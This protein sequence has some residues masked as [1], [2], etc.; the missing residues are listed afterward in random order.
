M[1]DELIKLDDSIEQHSVV[2][3]DRGVWEDEIIN[4]FSRCIDQLLPP[5][6]LMQHFQLD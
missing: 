1:I 6:K 3:Y 5:R 2:N 4:I